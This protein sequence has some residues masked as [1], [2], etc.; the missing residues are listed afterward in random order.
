[1]GR[2]DVYLLIEG[3]LPDGIAMDSADHLWIALWGAGEVRRYAPD[4]SLADRIRLPAPHTT[5]VAFAGDDLRR[6]IITT[7][8]TELS[9][10]QLR[11]FPDSGRIFTATVDV[12]GCPVAPWRGPR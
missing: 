11:A 12:G 1:V 10:E 2:R 5:S 7:A 8:T 4:R 9:R 6:L 3:G